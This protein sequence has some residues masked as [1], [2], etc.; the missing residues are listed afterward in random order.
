MDTKWIAAAF[1]FSLAGCTAVTPAPKT[2]DEVAALT[3]AL[4]SD[5]YAPSDAAQVV[6]PEIELGAMAWGRLLAIGD[7]LDF[8]LNC[9]LNN[10]TYRPN[11]TDRVYTDTGAKLEVIKTKESFEEL[12]LHGHDTFAI[13][14]PRTLIVD[15]PPAALRLKAYGSQSQRELTVPVWYV[16][17]FRRKLK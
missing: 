4:P 6:G 11:A 16:E 15:G 8:V 13:R 12:M 14:I 17:G 9:R 3:G 2:A 1:A 10:P 5:G 7:K